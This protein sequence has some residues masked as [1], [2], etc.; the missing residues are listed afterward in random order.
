MTADELRNR[1]LR[2]RV[3]TASPAQRVVMLYDRL[4][5]DLARAAGPN[6]GQPGDEQSSE[7]VDHAVQVVT[8]LLASLDVTA[9]GPSEN[10]S[11]IYGFLLRELLAIRL[12]EH[13]RLPG[14]VEIVI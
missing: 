6:D 12:G 9:G 8:E 10:L 1:Y 2:D 7:H 4:T 14:V 5:L 3:L 11:A 13:D